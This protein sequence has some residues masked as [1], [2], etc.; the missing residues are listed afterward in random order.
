[1][2]T[3]E[4]EIRVEGYSAGFEA[5]QTNPRLEDHPMYI[6]GHKEG[7]MAIKARIERNR[8]WA[9]D[10]RQKTFGA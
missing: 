10:L 8:Q 4:W 9:K 2:T 1:M 6:E 7:V 3:E 5:R